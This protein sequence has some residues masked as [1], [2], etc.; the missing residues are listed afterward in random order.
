MKVERTHG[1][2]LSLLAAAM[3]AGVPII[4]VVGFSSAA[5]A[6]TAAESDC[7]AMIG[8]GVAGGNT[9]STAACERYLSGTT[10]NIGGY[11]TGGT[12]TGHLEFTKFG[13]ATN[14]DMTYSWGHHSRSIT[15]GGLCGDGTVSTTLWRHNSGSNY[16]NMG[17]ARMHFTCVVPTSTG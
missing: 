5:G 15:S 16:T 14:Y 8:G 6:T 3:M 12:F 1:W 17:T 13:L 11:N 4:S 7:I 9:T 2:R 10:F